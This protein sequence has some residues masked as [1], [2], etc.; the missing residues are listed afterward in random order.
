MADSARMR[1]L[2]ALELVSYLQQLSMLPLEAGPEEWSEAGALPELFV[3]DDTL[4]EAAVR[5]V[6]QE[7]AQEVLAMVV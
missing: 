3:S 2:E 5:G 6:E 4:A 7:A 1:A